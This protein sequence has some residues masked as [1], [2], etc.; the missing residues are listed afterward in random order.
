MGAMSGDIR[1]ATSEATMGGSSSC[2]SVQEVFSPWEVGKVHKGALEV[3]STLGGGG[4]GGGGALETA[5]A[6]GEAKNGLQPAAG[7]WFAAV[8]G[9]SQTLPLSELPY[10]WPMAI[11]S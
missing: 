2:E 9:G 5:A 8:G 6:E 1:A 11:M 3:E 4:G 10:D 7:S